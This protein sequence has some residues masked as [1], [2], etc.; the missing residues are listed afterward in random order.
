MYEHSTLVRQEVLGGRRI[1]IYYDN[2]PSNP[3]TDMDGNLCTMVCSHRN[4]SLG[5]EQS[6]DL[7]ESLR[8]LVRQYVSL[9]ELML[10]AWRNG[11][12]DTGCCKL[13]MIC[14]KGTSA[15]Y[16]RLSY[17]GYRLPLRSH[18]ARLERGRHLRSPQGLHRGGHHRQ[19][20][21]RCLHRTA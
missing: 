15:N 13:E 14:E 20:F 21:Q 10:F 16:W 5:D 2:T 1:N 4:Y 12:N 11:R 18:R 6:D 9:K 8:N 17:Y 7:D 3:R 19:S